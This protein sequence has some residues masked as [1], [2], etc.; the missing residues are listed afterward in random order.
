[1]ILQHLQL[2]KTADFATL[3]SI[4]VTF[5]IETLDTATLSSNN[6]KNLR[7]LEDHLLH[8]GIS[9]AGSFKS[10]LVHVL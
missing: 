9:V 5:H 1:M 3:K 6:I 7:A 10:V 4:S 8:F 2:H